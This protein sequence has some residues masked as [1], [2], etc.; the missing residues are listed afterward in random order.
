MVGGWRQGKEQSIETALSQT[1]LEAHNLTARPSHE[2]LNKQMA[3]NF[4]QKVRACIFKKWNADN[5]HR[6][7]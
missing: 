5:T 2:S 3:L 6:R 1:E 4:A 7:E